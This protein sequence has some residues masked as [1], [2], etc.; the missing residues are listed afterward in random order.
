M[1]S[2][3]FFSA[4][5]FKGEINFLNKDILN[6]FYPFFCAIIIVKVKMGYN[7]WMWAYENKIDKLGMMVIRSQ[8]S[9]NVLQIF[10]ILI[11]EI[12]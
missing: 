5:T 1:F 4:W 2:Y 7:I 10:L 3:Y 11:T 12:E 8:F 9:T 6:F